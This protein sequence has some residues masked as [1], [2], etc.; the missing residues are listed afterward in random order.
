MKEESTLRWTVRIYSWEIHLILTLNHMLCNVKEFVCSFQATW[1]H[2]CGLPDSN[3]YWGINRLSPHLHFALLNYVNTAGNS[4]GFVLPVNA[5]IFYSYFFLPFSK[6]MWLNAALITER[7]HVASYSSLVSVFFI[8]NP[9]LRPYIV[10][11]QYF[12]SLKLQL[13]FCYGLLL[14][15]FCIIRI[16]F[17]FIKM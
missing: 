3:R 10:C 6:Q 15:L 5:I 11:G 12:L 14:Y 7:H 13:F 4:A 17:Y 8:L 2:C 16:L 9:T 1:T